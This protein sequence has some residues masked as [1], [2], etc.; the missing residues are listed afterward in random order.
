MKSRKSNSKP[1]PPAYYVA[2]QKQKYVIDYELKHVASVTEI[3]SESEMES[4]I[5]T[6]SYSESTSH[7]VVGSIINNKYRV[8]SKLGEGAFGKVLEVVNEHQNKVYALKV[9]SKLI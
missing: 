6:E 9:L 3:E 1:L 5:E 8:V 7:L 2:K 4:L